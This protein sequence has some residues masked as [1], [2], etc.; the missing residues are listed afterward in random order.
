MLYNSLGRIIAVFDASFTG[1]TITAAELSAGTYTSYNNVGLLTEDDN[2]QTDIL[3]KVVLNTSR[4][5]HDDGNGLNGN[6]DASAGTFVYIDNFTE[7]YTNG[8]T[9]QT[10]LDV[11]H[12]VPRIDR[13][14]LDYVNL[15]ELEQPNV[16]LPF[17]A[18]FDTRDNIDRFFQQLRR[19]PIIVSR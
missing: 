2:N 11:H 14:Y 15:S 5:V 1:T 8:K 3:K 4:I 16:V 6:D 10:L 17:F 7:F 19:L 12:L 18:R 9:L 13:D